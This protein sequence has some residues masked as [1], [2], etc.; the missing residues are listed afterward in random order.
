MESASTNIGLV[1]EDIPNFANT[2]T[3]MLLGE[4]VGEEFQLD[5]SLTL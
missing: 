3:E 5:G 1:V 4:A 2:Q